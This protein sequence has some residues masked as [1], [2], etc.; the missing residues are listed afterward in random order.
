MYKAL[1][2]IGGYKKDEEVPEA[3]ALAWS[4]AYKESPV[5]LVSGK[6]KSADK[7]KKKEEKVEEKEE[8]AGSPM[9]DDY[10]ARNPY[11]VKSNLMKD[12]LDKETLKQLLGLEFKGKKRNMIIDAIKDKL[13]EK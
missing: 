5:E 4:K 6:P 3:E 1:I 8:S 13:E 7:P 2:D 11:V 12:D 10:L 9:L